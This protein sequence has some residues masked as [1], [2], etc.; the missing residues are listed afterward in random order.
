MSI[1]NHVR[2]QIENRIAFLAKA[3]DTLTADVDS[4]I[5]DPATL[6]ASVR[7]RIE[8]EPNYFIGRPIDAEMLLRDMDAV[9]IDMSLSWLNP[10]VIE[11]VDDPAAN[12][13]MLS[14]AN[15]YVADAAIRHPERVYPAGW[16]DPKALGVEGARAVVDECVLEL[17]FAVVKLNPGQNAYPIDSDAALAVIERI[18]EL[19]AVPAFHFGSDTLYTPVQGLE[20]VAARFPDHPILAVHFGGVGAGMPAE[21]FCH[22]LRAMGLRRTN[23]FFV[24][25]SKREMHVESDLITYRLAGPQHRH[26]IFLGSDT[27]FGRPNWHFGGYR[28]MFATLADGANHADARVRAAPDQFD[29]ETAQDFMGRNFADFAAEACRRVL[30]THCRGES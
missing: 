7:N 19:G 29:A 11:Y 10:W 2:Q 30:A 24:E 23:I 6:P 18:V 27:P 9:G 22:E 21:A 3:R 15:H 20:N 16:T 4:H 5:S 12:R 1:P 14:R 28:Q 8:R 25:S 17:G 26:R 13:A